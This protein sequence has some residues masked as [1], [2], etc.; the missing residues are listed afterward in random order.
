MD[1]ASEGMGEK[2]VDVVAVKIIR[3]NCHNGICDPV[4]RRRSAVG[5]EG[6]IPL[7]DDV[8]G[9]F[10]RGQGQPLRILRQPTPAE[11]F[12]RE[13]CNILS[14]FGRSLRY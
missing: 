13:Y 7:I 8:D 4:V 10:L 2:A 6:E 5:A 12:F 1:P 11:G 14:S 9:E 3:V